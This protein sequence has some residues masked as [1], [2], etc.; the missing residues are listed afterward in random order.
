MAKSRR[1]FLKYGA[2]GLGAAVGCGT[3]WAA[4]SE[5]RSARWLRRIVE[6]SKRAML[7]ASEKPDPNGW[8]A[9]GITLAWLGH[10]TVLI[11]FYGV[12]ILTDPALGARIGVSVGIGVLGPK[13][14]IAPALTARQ[15]PPIDLV[16]LSHAHMDH[17]DT[18]TLRRIKPRAGLVT[19]K[20]TSEILPS[21]RAKGAIEMGWGDELRLKCEAGELE[22]R[23]FEV[24]HWGRRWPNDI[25]R[26][27]NGYVLRREG[28]ALLFGGDTAMTPLFRDVR[29]YGPFEAAIMPIAAYRPWIR[30]HCTPE[31]AVEMAN[32][33]RARYIL[34]VHHQTFKLS[35]EPMNEPME[36]LT[37]ALQR[38]PER[39]ALS[40]VG[41]TFRVP[42]T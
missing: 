4:V 40:E 32:A 26:G 27:Y 25:N 11:N 18:A 36:R 20:M 22:L 14:Y 15:L 6:D 10:A 21:A 9:N 8:P 13:R 16:L 5:R 33:A 23:A 29:A 12:R 24:K 28:K 7:P 39:L 30:N 37:A 1:T 31:E 17:L 2:V 38:E 34:P 35:D 3:W 42:L 19:S 41:Q